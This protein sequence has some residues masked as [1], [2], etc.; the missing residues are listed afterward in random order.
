[1]P[2]RGNLYRFTDT[3]ICNSP[4]DTGV[5]ALYERGELIYIGKGDGKGG[6][7]ARLQSHKRGDEGR[8][9][10]P[11]TSYR[12]ERSSNPSA[13]EIYLQEEYL[14]RCGRLPRCNDRIG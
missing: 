10:Q 1:M 9:T 4:T 8:C 2:I 11:A 13:R 12:R 5:Y 7:R 3:N 14:E 6:I